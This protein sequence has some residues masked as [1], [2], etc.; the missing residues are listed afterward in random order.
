MAYRLPNYTDL[1]DTVD[2]YVAAWNDLARPIEQAFNLT[3]SG[4]DP[5]YQFT[6]GN[7]NG[8]ATSITLP[9]WFVRELS[10]VLERKQP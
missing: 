1:V 3:L 6:K 5:D 4:F 10:Q 7:P 2:E 9:T 8:M